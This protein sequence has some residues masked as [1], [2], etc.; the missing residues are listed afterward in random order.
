MQ[1]SADFVPWPAIDDAL[2]DA[3]ARNGGEFGKTTDATKAG[4]DSVWRIDSFMA[5]HL[6]T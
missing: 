4:Q 1:R 6:I 3:V 2:S 5:V